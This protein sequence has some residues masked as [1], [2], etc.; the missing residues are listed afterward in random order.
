MFHQGL[1][2]K[3]FSALELCKAYLDKIKEGKEVHAFLTVNEN[4][5]LSQ[6]K[7]IDDL[8]AAGSKTPA[9]AGLPCAVKDNILV[10]NVK[11]TAGS[12]ILGNY[13]APYNATVIEKLKSQGAENCFFFNP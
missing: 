3:Q 9:L 4:L 5:A 10:E 7:K 6:A 2:K 1:K 13:I 11:C 8:I 12:K